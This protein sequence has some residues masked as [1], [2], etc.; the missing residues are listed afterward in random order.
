MSP[1]NLARRYPHLFRQTIWPWAVRA[2]FLILKD[3]P[4]PDLI[5]NV[6]IVPRSGKDWIIIRLK[7]GSWEIPGGTLEP[8]ET[9]LAASERELM[10]EAGALMDSF[11]LI[12]AWHCF[13][14][15]DKPYRPHLPFPE[16]YRVVGVCEVQLIGLPQN[17]IGGE[18]IVAVERVPL[19][20]AVARFESQQRYDLAEL[21][22]LSADYF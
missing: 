11:Q 22:Q 5:S 9:Y 13:S 21:C 15:A 2:Q 12:G 20:T 14:Q 17:P 18:E 7:D 4:P 19:K 16:F 6:K 3:A 10:E 1:E 8:S